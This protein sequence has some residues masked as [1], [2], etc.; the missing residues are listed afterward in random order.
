MRCFAG[1][2]ACQP[3]NFIRRTRRN[4]K[5]LF[6]GDYQTRVTTLDGWLALGAHLPPKE[7]RGVVLV[8]PP[9]EKEGEYDRLVDGLARAYGRWQTGSFCLWYPVKSGAPVAGF[10]EK[11]KVLGI[12]RILC[13]ELSVCDEDEIDGLCGSGVILVN[14]P[15]TLENELKVILPVLE[16]CLARTAASGHRLIWLAGE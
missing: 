1:R 8:D 15:F 4:S 16:A 10:H 6:D 3:S 2:T 9:F 14:P 5:Q 12:P 13:A 11:L 7:R